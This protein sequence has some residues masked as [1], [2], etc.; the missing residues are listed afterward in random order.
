MRDFYG[1]Q[2][3]SH[4]G[5]GRVILYGYECSEC[6]LAF[7]AAK[8]MPKA[9]CPACWRTAVRLGAEDA[10]VGYLTLED[11]RRHGVRSLQQA[12]EVMRKVN[13]GDVLMQVEI[14]AKRRW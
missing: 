13:W 10:I 6:H 3:E 8:N 14:L 5:G 7:W 12:D 11:I 1:T 4:K 9:V 2:A